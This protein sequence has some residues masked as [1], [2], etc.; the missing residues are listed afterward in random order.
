M[1]SIVLG[2]GAA[3]APADVRACSSDHPTFEEAVRG[4]RAIARVTIVDGFDNF[5]DD[6]TTSETYRVE[7]VL[8]GSLPGVV[9]VAPA[10]TSLCHDSVGWYAGD[11]ES[12]GRTIIV[13][14]DLRYYDQVIHPMWIA[15]KIE[16]VRGSADVP[17]GARTLAGLEAAILAQLGVP[18]TSTEEPASTDGYGVLLILVAAVG[19]LLAFGRLS[20][21]D[22]LSG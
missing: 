22:R 16:G 9:T 8:K 10:W 13:A 2:L 19:V 20:Q 17:V 3:F 4:A 5:L 1:L 11:L 15:D 6:P 18:E 12:D 7:K 21:G 14:L